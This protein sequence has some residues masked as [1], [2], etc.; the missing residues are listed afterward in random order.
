MGSYEMSDKDANSYS[1]REAQRRFKKVLR[2]ALST[3]P[4]PLKSIPPKEKKGS[5]Q[6][7]ASQLKRMHKKR[8]AAKSGPLSWVTKL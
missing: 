6:A 8:G 7:K 5:S 1:E 2:G 3:P 4:K